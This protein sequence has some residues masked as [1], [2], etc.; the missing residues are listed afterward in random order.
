M[1]IKQLQSL[2]AISSRNII[3]KQITFRYPEPLPADQWADPKAPEYPDNPEIVDGKAEVFVRKRSAADFMELVSSPDR[4][5][6]CYSILRCVCNEDG[7]P[8]F[9]SYEQVDNLADWMFVPLLLAV[10]EVNKITP[11]HLPPRTNSGSTSPSR[12]GAGRSR[13][14]K[15]S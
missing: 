11:K 3:K 9:E 7:S 14:G 13:S 6:G 4:E 15:K 2:G 1:D 12:S 5:K 10:N 8:L